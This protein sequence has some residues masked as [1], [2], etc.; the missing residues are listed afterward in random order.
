MKLALHDIDEQIREVENRIAVERIA[1]DDGV[2]ACKESLKETLTSPKTLL[3]VLG[4][5]FTV[6]K[7]LFRQKPPPEQSA[8]VKKAGMLGLLTGVAGTAL[9]L[10]NTRSGWGGVARWA[11]GRY[12]SRR[13]A[14]RAAGAPVG[15]PAST[16]SVRAAAPAAT[17]PLRPAAPAAAAPI[18]ASATA[19]PSGGA[20]SAAYPRTSART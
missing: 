8:P 20:T 2:N 12:F 9:S 1:L 11:A 14:A 13:K 7:V 6:G 15:V 4:V 16:A 19:V 10:A 17:T 5:G 18:G 3:T